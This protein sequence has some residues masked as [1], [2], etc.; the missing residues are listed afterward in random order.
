MVQLDG[1]QDAETLN[2]PTTS[3]F[4][5]SD[6]E[7]ISLPGHSFRLGSHFH[8]P[9]YSRSREGHRLVWHPGRILLLADCVRSLGPLHR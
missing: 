1:N 6:A 5:Q 4:Q 8:L 2:L 9:L 7:S 3:R